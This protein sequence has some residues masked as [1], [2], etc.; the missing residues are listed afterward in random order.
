MDCSQFK[1]HIFA[2]RDGT[3]SETMSRAAECH[4]STCDTCT[5][6]MAEFDRMDLV[7]GLDKAAEPNPFAATRLLMRLETEF[8][9]QENHQ[10][11]YWL[12]ILQPLTLAVAVLCGILIGSY[13]AKQDKNQ[14]GSL[15]GTSANVEFL[16]TDL[17]ISEFADEDKTV[18]LNK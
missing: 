8:G 17:F 3:L 10:S 4:L 1:S 13:T 14:S 12:R 2:F 18:D 16:R 9:A 7:V 11:R 5:G 15:A 6:L